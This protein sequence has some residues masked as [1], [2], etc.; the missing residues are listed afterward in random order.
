MGLMDEFDRAKE[1]VKTELNINRN[2]RYVNLFE[3]TIRVLG[4]LLSSYALSGEQVFFDKA[5]ELGDALLPAFE[6]P[7]GIPFSDV[8][9]QTGRV[10]GPKNSPK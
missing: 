7:T 9:L 4:G 3:T 2:D 6:S 1:W 5:K 10:K 8:N